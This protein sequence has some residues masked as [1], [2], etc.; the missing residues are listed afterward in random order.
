MLRRYSWFVICLLFGIFT[1]NAER[2]KQEVAL[3]VGDSQ[4]LHSQALL[5]GLESKRFRYKLYSLKKLKSLPYDEI[6][7]KYIDS[8]T[9]RLIDQNDP[10]SFMSIE[11]SHFWADFL[12]NRGS[13][14]LFADTLSENEHVYKA[15]LP[16]YVGF[17]SKH[18]DTQVDKIIGSQKDLISEGQ[19]LNIDSSKKRDQII[20]R[21]G[22]GI[23][24]VYQ[25][26]DGT[27]TGIKQQTCNFRM[28]Y[29]TFLPGE[30]VDLK[31]RHNFIERA[32]DWN[33]GYALAKG[34]QAPDFNIILSNGTPT[35]IYNVYNKLK[36]VVILEF[37]ATWC[38]SC[39]KQLHRMLALK[40]EFRDADVS[41]IFI[42]YKE[43]LDIVQ[44]Y[45]KSHPEITWPIA[46]TPDGMGALRYGVKGLPG[47]F[48][49]DSNRKVKFIN[50]GQISFNKLKGEITDILKL[51]KFN[52][53][54]KQVNTNKFHIKTETSVN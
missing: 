31:I 25:S 28:S 11:E 41:F 13:L 45:L 44:N 53:I 2:T 34:M 51:E 9:I 38:S 48:V 1:S 19:I 39:A 35:G 5:K 7:N 10:H 32:I 17:K 54:Y 37:M 22:S 30:I 16:D 36:S 3:I 4:S 21:T 42:S 27:I 46:I 43:N 29:F 50:K 15:D 40:K 12:S 8:A 47:I 52:S 24:V 14:T 33:L 18:L 26:Q 20:P 23:D 6:F 49:L